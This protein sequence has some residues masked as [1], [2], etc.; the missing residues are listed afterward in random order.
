MD[1]ACVYPPKIIASRPPSVQHAKCRTDAQR[2]QASGAVRG[3][4]LAVSFSAYPLPC[5]AS[6]KA[7]DGKASTYLL[8]SICYHHNYLQVQHL[9][10]V[11]LGLIIDENDPKQQCLGSFLHMTVRTTRVCALGV[12]QLR[13]ALPAHYCAMA[14]TAS[15]FM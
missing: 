2:R 8:N 5:A 15:R 9:H 1:K 13:T 10:A 6:H 12:I 3:G 4:G 14:C 7:N 11:Q